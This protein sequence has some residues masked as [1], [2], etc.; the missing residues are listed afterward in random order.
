M[1]RMA[2]VSSLGEIAE[3]FKYVGKEDDIN[4][5]VQIVINWKCLVNECGPHGPFA[6]VFIVCD[7]FFVHLTVE[8]IFG[9]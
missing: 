9:R 6:L 4:F 2:A 3:I 5:E 1:S 8:G 7:A